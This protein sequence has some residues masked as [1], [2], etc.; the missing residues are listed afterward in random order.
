[1]ELTR[2]PSWHAATLTESQ[3]IRLRQEL[4]DVLGEAPV[5]ETVEQAQRLTFAAAVMNETL[6]VSP[7]VPI[8]YLEATKDTLLDDVLVPKGTAVFVLTRAATRHGRFGAAGEFR[9]ER[10]LDDERGAI[11]HD[12]AA[13]IPFGSGPR[14]CPGRALAH[15]EGRVALAH[16]LQ[17]L[18]RRTHRQ[19]AG[20]AI[21]GAVDPVRLVG[22]PTRPGPG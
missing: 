12:P 21:H 18:R 6:R 3:S 17:E 5:P 2:T 14:L 16:T 13:H 20:R 4:D 1:L 8:L 11:A 15:L 19:R 10:W 7:I 9:P 22:A